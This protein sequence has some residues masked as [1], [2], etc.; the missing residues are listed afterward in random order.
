MN[1]Q[2]VVEWN[3]SYVAYIQSLSLDVLVAYLP[4]PI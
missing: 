1:Q 3:I 4:L 2:V